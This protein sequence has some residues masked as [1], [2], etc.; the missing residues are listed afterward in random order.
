MLHIP[1]QDIFNTIT[2]RNVL[3]TSYFSIS[4]FKLAMAIYTI[5]VQMFANMSHAGN[6]II[7][8]HKFSIPAAEAMLG[9]I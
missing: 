7:N 2:A 6:I 4:V 8:Y 1:P 9:F 3:K 5:I